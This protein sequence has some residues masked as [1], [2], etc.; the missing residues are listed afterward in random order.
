MGPRSTAGTEQGRVVDGL[1]GEQLGQI[2]HAGREIAFDRVWMA[3][4]PAMGRFDGSAD[5]YVI[6]RVG[7]SRTVSANTARWFCET[8]KRI[9][10][11]ATVG[12]DCVEDLDGLGDPEDLQILLHMLE[13]TE[14][15]TDRDEGL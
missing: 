9:V 13:L 4:D 14:S 15:L 8:V 7:P 11:G 3:T 10:P 1:T 5:L 2:L 6:V 12:V